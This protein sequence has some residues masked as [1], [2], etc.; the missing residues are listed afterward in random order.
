MSGVI[1]VSTYY[2]IQR[3]VIADGLFGLFRLKRPVTHLHLDG[4]CV[5]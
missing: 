3:A 5:A 2:A 4:R 1:L